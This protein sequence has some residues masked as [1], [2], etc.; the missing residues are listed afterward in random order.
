[1]GAAHHG[2]EQARPNPALDAL[3]KRFLDQTEG[4]AKRAYSEGRVGADDDGDLAMAVG[5]DIGARIVRVDFGKPVTWLGMP[6][7]Q[8]VGLAKLLI[9]HA[10]AVSSKPLV[11]EIG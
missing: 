4:R 7:E 6:P 1:M 5:H 2:S 8:A 9:Q 10:R 11:V 3:M